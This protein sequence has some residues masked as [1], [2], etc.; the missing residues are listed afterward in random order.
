VSKLFVVVRYFVP[1]VGMKV[2]LLKFKSLQVKLL[3]YSAKIATY[4]VQ[5][6]YASRPSTKYFIRNTG[7]GSDGRSCH[8]RHCP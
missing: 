2:K 8:L 3:Q 7:T 5:F 4:S 1:D 6:I